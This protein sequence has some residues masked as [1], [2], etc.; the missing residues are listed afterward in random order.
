MNNTQSVRAQEGQAGIMGLTEEER[1][2]LNSVDHY[3]AAGLE[4]KQWWTH[5]SATN[6]FAERFELGLSYNRPDTGYG[7]FDETRVSVTPCRSWATCKGCCLTGRKFRVSGRGRGTGDA[8]SD[9][10]VRPALL[11]ARQLFRQ[12]Q[13]T[14]ANQHPELPFYLRPFSLCLPD[15]PRRVGFGFRSTSTSDATPVRSAASLRK[16]VSASSICATSAR[17]TS[18][19]WRGCVSMILA[20]LTCRSD[21]TP[22]ILS[23]RSVRRVTSSSRAISLRMSIIPPRVSWV[24]MAWGMPL[25]RIRPRACRRTDQGSSMLPLRSSTSKCTTT[26]KCVSRCRLSSIDPKNSS[27]FPSTLST[28]ALRA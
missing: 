6:R 9:P 14:T 7:F 2:V 17:N 16:S 12:P 3:L 28:W 18:G 21:R 13:G 26:G 23:C 1:A 11:H 15:D 20:L 4:L 22:P 10:R 25:S 5:A 27:I 24:G 8:R 19:L